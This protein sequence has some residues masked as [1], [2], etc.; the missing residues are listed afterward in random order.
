MA[1]NSPAPIPLKRSIWS[2]WISLAGTVIAI[3]SFFAFLLLFA[4]DLF[5]GEHGNPYVGILSYV[6]APGF[7]F[8]G[9]GLFLLGAWF[10][11]RQQKRAPDA[12]TPQLSIDLENPRDRKRLL[13]FAL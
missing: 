12:P 2:N 9:L 5:A 6:V 1:D 13:V 10:S 8:L 7:L 4:F 11:R 3:G